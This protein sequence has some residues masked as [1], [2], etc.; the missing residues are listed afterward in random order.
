MKKLFLLIATLSV[1]SIGQALAQT[2]V[3]ESALIGMWRMESL[4]YEGED[5]YVC[6]N[7]YTQ[8]KIYRANGEYACAE[9]LSSNQ[10]TCKVLPHEY[11]KYTF[12]NG[13]YTEMG[14][15]GNLN[16]VDKN[17][18]TGTWKTR[19]DKWK[20]VANPPKELTDYIMRMCKDSQGNA[21]TDALIKQ[22]LLNKK[23]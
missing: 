19:H 5:K 8:V 3:P 22:Y 21:K 13:Q 18:F 16:L 20:K 11:G 10:G 1:M 6:E 2:K 9:I 17:T 4:Q 12:K 7:E 14:R 23:K 15:K